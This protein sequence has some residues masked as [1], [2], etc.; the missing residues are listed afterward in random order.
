MTTSPAS[1]I[2]PSNGAP[3]IFSVTTTLGATNHLVLGYG[4][5]DT[6]SAQFS[7]WTYTMLNLSISTTFFASLTVALTLSLSACNNPDDKKVA[8]QVAAKVGTEEI[9]VSQVNQLLRRTST[10][11]TSPQ[12]AQAM[13][14]EVL[15]KLIDQ[16]LA[17]EQAKETKLDRSPDVVSQI[18]A[19][20]REILARAYLQQ[21]AAGLPTPTD[22]EIK[23]YFAEH[24]QL[25]AERR[26][27]S[28]QEIVTPVAP[29]VA[30]QLRSFAT[31]GK[32]IE[33]AAA[34]LKSKDIKFGGASA[35][36]AAEQIPL[37]VLTQIHPL[38]DGQ[39][40]VIEGPKGITFL[41]IVSSQ[42]APVD[43]A[44]ALPRIK[45]F[46]V[47]Q[48]ASEVVS[49]KIKQ[50]REKAQI[51]YL[52]DFAKAVGTSLPESAAS[53]TPAND[54]RAKTTTQKAPAETK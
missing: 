46:L 45:Q 30:E 49:E 15:E 54:N 44:A 48:H 39:N 53:Q 3:T 52:G 1:K 51:T 6:I 35:T 34:W 5:M 50:L 24:S 10:A 23:K 31:A 42:L 16:Q 20:R 18:E 11:G 25:F 32:P 38:K 36:R 4:T 27:F 17:V 22:N 40:L 28:M 8:P 41:R 29:G 37:D 14:R 47:N 21:I 43:E 26:I 33:E 9:S 7:Y 2:C 19:A 13:G 12:T